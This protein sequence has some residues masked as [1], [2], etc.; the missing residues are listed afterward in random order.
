MGR[1]K[2]DRWTGTDGK[3]HTKVAIVAE[4][5]EYRVDVKKDDESAS[6][7]EIMAEASLPELHRETAEG[8]SKFKGIPA[9]VVGA[10]EFQAVTF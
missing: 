4:H 10:E 8:R 1:L 2:Q 3:N 9:E 7:A 5:V 6:E